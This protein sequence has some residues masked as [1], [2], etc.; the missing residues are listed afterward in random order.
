MKLVPIHSDWSIRVDGPL[1]DGSYV[2]WARLE[3]GDHVRQGTGTYPAAAICDALGQK[4]V[5][6]V[7]EEG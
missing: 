1:S 2:A 4:V 5:S 6:N 7:G 3:G